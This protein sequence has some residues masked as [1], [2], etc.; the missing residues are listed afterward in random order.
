MMPVIR[1]RTRLVDREVNRIPIP[2]RQF[3]RKASHQMGALSRR[4]LRRHVH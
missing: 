2:I 4:Q 3:S 1:L